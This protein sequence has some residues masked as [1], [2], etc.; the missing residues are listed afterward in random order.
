MADEGAA[1]LCEPNVAAL[2][3]RG[4]SSESGPAQGEKDLGGALEVCEEDGSVAGEAGKREE[5]CEGGGEVGDA[6]ACIAACTSLVSR[7]PVAD[8]SVDLKTSWSPHRVS[9]SPEAYV[10]VSLSASDQS[11]VSVRRLV[12]LRRCAFVCPQRATRVVPR[13]LT[14]CLKGPLASGEGSL[15]PSGGLT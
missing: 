3:D 8:A 10:S 11:C 12:S 13:H 7:R 1:G 5:A 6:G 2:S 14:A 15:C 4:K 9:I